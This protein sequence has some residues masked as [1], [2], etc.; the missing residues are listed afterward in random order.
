M[1]IKEVTDLAY[2]NNDLSVL[3]LIGVVI[4]LFGELWALKYM[5]NIIKL[6]IISGAAEFG[7]V[8]LGFGMG[9]YEG[10][11]GSL[12]HIEYQTIMRILV[13]LCTYAL[14]KKVGSS[15]IKDLQG[16]GRKEPLLGI[17]FGFG[18]FAIMGLS[19]FKGSISKF[20]IIYSSIESGAY[21]Y[22]AI[23]VFAS[24]IEAIYFLY[25]IQKVCFEAPIENMKI[26]YTNKVTSLFLY[27]FIYIFSAVTIFMTLFPNSIIHITEA[28]AKTFFTPEAI[29]TL[30]MFEKPWDS[31]VLIPYLGA[32]AVFI[33]GLISVKL[34]NIFAI[35]ISAYSLYYVYT[36]IEVDAL[37]KLFALII[38]G[39][40]FL[41][42]LYST[43]YFSKK[44]YTNRYFFFLLLM[45]GV[46][47]GVSTA[48]DFGSFYLYW[49][50]MTWTSYLLVIH[51][52]SK[53]ALKAGFKYF[54]MCTSGAYFML[55][56]ILL[57]HAEVGSFE[58]GIVTQNINLI[59]STTLLLI[60]GMFIIGF[61]VK[62][63]LVPMHSWLPDAHPVAPSSI[64]A[65]MSGILTKTGIYGLIQVL[66]VVFG[67]STLDRFGVSLG[68]NNIGV[69][70]S[71]LGALTFIVGEVMALRQ[72]DIKKMLAYSTMAQIGELTI[73]LGV[74][75]YLSMIGSLSHVLNHA[76]MKNLLFLAVG[77]LILRTKSQSIKDFKGIATQMPI[78]S[79]LF[80]IGILAIMGLPPFNGFVSKYLMLFANIQA[81]HIELAVLILIGSVIGA[82]YYVRLLQV[83][84]F[85]KYEGPPLKEAPLPILITL[86]VLGA[87]VLV[88]GVYPEFGLSFVLPAV[89]YIAVSS[90]MNIQEIPLISATWSLPI[91][92]PMIGALI[93]YFIGKYSIKL[94]GFSTV[95]LLALTTI[96]IFW[97]MDSL[98][99]FS[100]SFAFLIAFM[101]VLNLLYSVGYMNHSHSQNRFYMFFLLMIGGLM[102]V[103]TS[104]DLFSFFLYWEIMSSWTL[105]FIIIHEQTQT[106]LKEGFKYFMFNYIGASIMFLG[107]LILSTNLESFA[108]SSLAQS[109]ETMPLFDASL[110]LICILIGFGMK[111]AMLPIRIDYQM[112]PAAAPT[113]VSGYISAVLLK[114]APFGIGK[115]I[116]AL[117]GVTVVS[118][119][120][121]SLDMAS[122]MYI[123][124]WISGITIFV[125]AALAIVQSGIKLMLIYSTVSQIGYVM[126]GIS[127]GTSLGVAGGLLHLIN[128]MIFKDLLFLVAGAI[129][130]K[131]G[132]DTLDKIGGLG[133]KMPITL[134][135]FV[136]GV[137]AVAGVPPFN[138]FTS[139]WLI[140]QAAM[141]QGYV[142]LALI[143]LLTSV[144]T[145]AYFMKF[146]HSAFFG[147]LPRNLENVKEVS[148]IMLA[149]MV[150]L[151]AS[152][153]IFGIFPGILLDVISQIVLLFGLEGLEVSLFGLTTGIGA[154][155]PGVIALLLVIAMLV[156]GSVYF[157]G[158]K[159]VRYAKIYTC[160]VLNL[161]PEELHVN[162]HNLYETPKKMIQGTTQ[163]L[164]NLITIGKGN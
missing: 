162:S 27:L 115:F 136:I 59:P 67:I 34:R 69:I 63:G 125:A 29:N 138:G 28:F 5:K 50:L 135:T 134:I 45:S 163:K 49:E 101:G 100:Y 4:L 108:F 47:L 66:Y 130:Y 14:I 35:L 18:I 109:F 102:G 141:E 70:I 118:K 51:K 113:P 148:W 64:S 80:G 147:Q 114:S 79:F 88:N 43:G 15:E 149:P 95:I 33:V 40:S 97:L 25:V 20:L 143:S 9:T 53:E 36:Y 99:I 159:N 52:Q 93:V 154:W 81:G 56:A 128:H 155:N 22:A 94:S 23:G 85:E 73:T 145:L 131:T 32:F 62:A 152:C 6:L 65:P 2:F 74:G 10:L 54:I 26:V 119:I 133:K 105:Y 61:G 39:I 84:F 104:K 76:I 92:I 164:K 110:A 121:A 96:A 17:L 68:I 11:C 150:I 124:A 103:A 7:Y 77:A 142:F 3:S 48:K 37:S 91:I 86:G 60:T 72:D 44:E 127:L 158:N 126:L 87:L 24:I 57:I 146:L 55:Y 160:G 139:K 78:T 75:T 112:H 46:L 12:L 140:Y 19:P 13:F 156:G 144:I 98:D 120:A 1:C 89:E 151:A 123:L 16:V 41:I 161:E 116:F 111:A 129:M 90:S 157:L 106:A 132:I 137:F 117:G 153:I 42:V 38:S 31:V 21:F 30:P 71:L 83:V 107:I 8:L 58:M 82:F 122:I